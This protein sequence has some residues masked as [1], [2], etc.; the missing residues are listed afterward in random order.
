MTVCLRPT[1]FADVR[2]NVD[3]LPPPPPPALQGAMGV[4][5]RVAALAGIAVSLYALHVETSI[6][7]ARARGEEYAAACDV[8]GFASC[9]KVLGST[10]Q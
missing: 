1:T 9:S 8:K 10:C 5:V 2:C 3:V 4:L 7:A 6:A